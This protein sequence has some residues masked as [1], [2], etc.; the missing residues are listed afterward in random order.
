MKVFGCTVI[1]AL[2]EPWLMEE[3]HTTEFETSNLCALMQAAVV[4]HLVF[5]EFRHTIFDFKKKCCLIFSF[6]SRG[7]AFDFRLHQTKRTVTFSLAPEIYTECLISSLIYECSDSYPHLKIKKK[8]EWNLCGLV[9]CVSSDAFYDFF[10]TSLLRLQNFIKALKSIYF[11]GVLDIPMISWVVMLVSRLLDYVATVEDEAATA[12]KPLN[13][14][15]RER[16][17]TGM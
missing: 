8:G 6:N 13:G 3:F 11:E 15:E 5:R 14:K 7:E 9:K 4:L 16:F 1:T 10:K 12:K 2:L 17:L